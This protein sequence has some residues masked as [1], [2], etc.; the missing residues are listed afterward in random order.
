MFRYVVRE[1]TFYIYIQV[2]KSKTRERH[3]IYE[4]Q[5]V[6]KTALKW[7]LFTRNQVTHI[8]FIYTLLHTLN[9]N[10]KLTHARTHAHTFSLALAQSIS[11]K[12][13]N[14]NANNVV[15][16]LNWR[17][18]RLWWMIFWCEPQVNNTNYRKS[19]VILFCWKCCVFVV[20]LRAKKACSF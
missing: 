3:G 5:L 2:I 17:T 16:S 14:G 19:L 4:A 18:N 20:E 7:W 13:G 15:F 6:N 11:N 12:M 1:C 10:R 9:R 8:K